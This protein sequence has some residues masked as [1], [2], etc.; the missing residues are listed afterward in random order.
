M[1]APEARQPVAYNNF[2]RQPNDITNA[3]I[4]R[5]SVSDLNKHFCSGFFRLLLRPS[6][7]QSGPAT[8]R[9][10]KVRI[11]D[12]DLIAKFRHVRFAELPLSAA[13]LHASG[14]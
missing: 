4:G 14:A 11:K 1:W 9:L 3:I 13:W 12:M 5:P 7:H 10:Q 6:D 8:Y 2:I